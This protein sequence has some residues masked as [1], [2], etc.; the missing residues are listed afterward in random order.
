MLKYFVITATHICWKSFL[1][2]EVLSFLEVGWNHSQLL[3]RLYRPVCSV[4]SDSLV[5]PWSAAHQAPL[6]LGFSRQEY[7]GCHFHLQGIFPTQGLNL[8]LLHCRQIL[9]QLNHFCK[10]GIKA[11]AS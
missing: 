11:G 4:G 2:L 9:Y 1:L 7:C 3:R 5:T 8:G 6:S 10:T